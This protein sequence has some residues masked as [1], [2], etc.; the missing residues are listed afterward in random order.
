LHR[1]IDRRALAPDPGGAGS[2]PCIL[3]VDDDIRNVYAMSSL[4][5]EAGMRVCVASNGA[6]A[7]DRVRDIQGIDLILMDMMMPVL[8]GYQATASLR[9]DLN[10]T[11]PILAVTASAMKGDREKCLAV[12]ADD[13]LAK[14]VKKQEL[15]ALIDKLL[16]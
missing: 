12:G 5:E 14:P 16:A 2:G 7:L 10:F 4:L 13:Y 8:D 15:L 1:E 3:L 6:Q 11:K 9:R